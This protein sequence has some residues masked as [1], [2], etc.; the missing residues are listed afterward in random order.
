ML[1]WKEEI[2][3]Y[4]CINQ[5]EINTEDH[6]S[7]DFIS[8][9]NNEYNSNELENWVELFNEIDETKEIEQEYFIYFMQLNLIS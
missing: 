8:E 3:Q 2:F 9:K 6:F 7:Y 1:E 5:G 4:N